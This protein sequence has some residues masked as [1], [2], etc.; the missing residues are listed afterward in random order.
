MVKIFW[1][2]LGKIKLTCV[3]FYFAKIFYFASMGK[4]MGFLQEYCFNILDSE[5]GKIGCSK[6]ILH[7][8]IYWRGRGVSNEENIMYIDMGL[9]SNN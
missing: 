5:K 4:S 3:F 2:S 7:I 8:F 1:E 9:Q 6:L